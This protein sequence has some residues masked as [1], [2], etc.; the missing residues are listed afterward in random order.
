MRKNLLLVLIMLLVTGFPAA[1]MGVDDTSFTM[2]F[3]DQPSVVNVDDTTFVIS[4]LNEITSFSGQEF[5]IGDVDGSGTTDVSDA[6]LILRHIVGIIELT[7]E[8]LARADVDG[9]GE[10]TVKDAILVLRIIVGLYEDEDEDEG[11][12]VDDED[13]DGSKGVLYKVDGGE[14]EVYLFGSVHYGI[15]DIYPLHHKVYEAFRKSDVLYLEYVFTEDNIEESMQELMQYGFYQDGSKL[16]DIVPPDIIQ[17]AVNIL[18]EAYQIPEIELE[19]ME[20]YKPWYL[21]MELSGAALIEEEFS[22]ELGIETYLTEKAVNYGMELLSLET[23]ADQM[24]PFELL[25]DESQL[26]YLQRTLETIPYI[27]ETIGEL[28]SEWSKGC[29]D[30]LAEARKHSIQEAATESLKLFETA[31]SDGRDKK[32][33]ETILDILTGEDGKTYFITVGTLHLVGENSIV[34]LLQKEGYSVYSVY[35]IKTEATIP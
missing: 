23:I 31:M 26:L 12:D 8:E 27:K 17:E 16:S 34:D 4:G 28:I 20:F 35:D 22:P 3:D 30:G 13:S 24:Q 9:D 14:N 21:A 5:D 11:E 6:I 18:K 2:G 25:S 29:V 33:T 10:V 1:V 7:D 15:E 32:M 19:Q